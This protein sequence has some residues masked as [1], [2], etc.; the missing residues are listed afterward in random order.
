MS[1]WI[2]YS[3]V[4]LGIFGAV[5]LLLFVLGFQ[6]WVALLFA[7]VISFTAGYIFFAKTRDEIVTSLRERAEKKKAA[8]RDVDAEVEDSL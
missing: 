8:S 1:P 5:F 3:L 2:R 6:W 4:R 7:T